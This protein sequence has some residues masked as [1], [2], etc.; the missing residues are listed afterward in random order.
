MATHYYSQAL[1]R[2]LTT[3]EAEARGLG[4]QAGSHG[5]GDIAARLAE[6]I[7]RWIDARHAADPALDL[8]VQA[9]VRRGWV[10]LP[11]AGCSACSARRRRLNALLPDVRS[12]AAWRALAKRLFKGACGPLKPAS[13]V[14]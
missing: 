4:G 13:R 3:S 12:R 2:L 1:G 11:L 10:T 5:L 14:R 9:A 6:P 8:A 7:A